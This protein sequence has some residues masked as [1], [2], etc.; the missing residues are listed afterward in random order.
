MNIFFSIDY[1]VL[2][3]DPY[4]EKKNNEYRDILK[5][6]RPTPYRTGIAEDY[7]SY[8]AIILH[9]KDFLYKISHRGWGCM[10][11]VTQVI[12]VLLYQYANITIFVS[13]IKNHR[14]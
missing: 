8:I 10:K 7:P 4:K 2:N 11:V 12:S 13:E 14:V 5:R 6:P 1:L 3:R 9:G